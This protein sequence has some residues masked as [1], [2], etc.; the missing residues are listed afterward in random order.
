M[1]DPGAVGTTEQRPDI[2]TLPQP[3][4]EG[5]VGMTGGGVHDQ[6]RG[7]VDHRQP[8][9]FVDDAHLDRG[10]AD[11]RCGRGRWLVDVDRVRVAD[12]LARAAGTPVDADVSRLDECMRRRA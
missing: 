10:P 8:L 6:A 2:A 1:D 9:V 4:G 5:A 12:A 11:R 3:V 7:L